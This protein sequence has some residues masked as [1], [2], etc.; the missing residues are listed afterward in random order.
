[1]V[2]GQDDTKELGVSAPA[3]GEDAENGTS[4]DGRDQHPTDPAS[5]EA[6]DREVS[7]TRGSTSQS[8]SGNE[9]RAT[10]TGD[11]AVDQ[12]GQ[13]RGAQ[14]QA[15]PIS[16]SP[17]HRT[18]GTGPAGA[19]DPH[20]REAR[21]ELLNQ[22]Y[23]TLRVTYLGAEPEREETRVIHERIRAKL[24][25]EPA[26]RNAYEIEQLLAF[27]MTDEQLETELPR[28]MAEAKSM[29]LS[30][31]DE[32]SQ[33]IA[34]I[35]GGSQDSEPTEE[36]KRKDQLALRSVLHRL[37]NDLQW[38]YDQR[39]RRRD[40]AKRLSVRVSALFL[41]AF[42]FFF[43]LLFIQYFTNLTDTKSGPAPQSQ[44]TAAAFEAQHGTEAPKAS[45]T[46]GQ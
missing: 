24:A 2:D 36:Q 31:V 19:R 13:G 43:G 33:R 29:K 18:Q 27:V 12:P 42:F 32:L 46:K 10:D 7:A 14:G 11:P 45:E 1:M 8:S 15:T 26:W 6:T 44:S 40:A 5:G 17:T 39:I 34:A 25:D 35:R 41:S 23:A 20:D 38:F 28:R 30:F 21:E 9:N 4:A 3:F 37:L 16:T 22:F